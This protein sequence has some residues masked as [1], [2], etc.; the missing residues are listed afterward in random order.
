MASNAMTLQDM[1]DFVRDALETDSTDLPDSILDRY[2]IDGSNRVDGFTTDWQF[3]AVDYTFDVSANTQSY[4]V[5][6][7]TLASGITKPLARI[8]DLRGPNWSLAPKDHAHMRSRYRLSSTTTGTPSAYSLWGNA[9]Y[10]WPTPSASDTYSITGYRQ[11]DDWVSTNAAPDFPDDMHELIAWWALNRAHAREGDP[12]MADFY[13]QEFE[14]ELKRRADVYTTGL[15]AQP[16][17]MGGGVDR[18]AWAAQNGLGPLIY[19]WE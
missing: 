17:I 15:D 12:Q 6:G 7:A 4:N 8:I 10:L 18:E 19:D 9:I 3:R 5:K 11:A 14:R 1:R 16:L 2:I 13:R